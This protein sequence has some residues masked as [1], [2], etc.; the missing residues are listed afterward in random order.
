MPVVNK[1]DL[2]HLNPAI[3]LPKEQTIHSK[4]YHYKGQEVIGDGI[5]S[6][7]AGMFAPAA[8]LISSNKD[9][10]VN[11]A[12]GAAAVGGL[13]SIANQV[14]QS[15]KELKQLEAIKKLR[16]EVAARS[17]NTKISE[18]AKKKVANISKALITEAETSKGKQGD[19]IFRF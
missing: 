2:R 16:E 4:I 9:I 18:D 11:A 6:G 3:K 7:L 14:A 13:A 1:T 19:G 10:I 8:K 12:K 17:E 5:F 15:N